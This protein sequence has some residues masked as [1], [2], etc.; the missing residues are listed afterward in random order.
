MP[1]M[2]KSEVRIGSEISFCHLCG[3]ELKE[4]SRILF[5]HPKD[6]HP[7]YEHRRKCS[8]SRMTLWQRI[9][10]LFDIESHDCFIQSQISENI[11]MKR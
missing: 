2:S 1:Y 3:S 8:G 7:V 5:Y 4:T 6:A 11:W 10:D 9:K